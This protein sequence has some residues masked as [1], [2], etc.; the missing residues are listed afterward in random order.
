MIDSKKSIKT[1]DDLDI[2]EEEFYKVHNLNKSKFL[3]C[4]YE[5]RNNLSSNHNICDCINTFDYLNNEEYRNDVD[6][7]L[8]LLAPRQELTIRLMAGLKDNKKY[9]I[10]EICKILLVTKGRV[11][12]IIAKANH[13]LFNIAMYNEKYN[14]Q[15]IKTST[16]FP[17]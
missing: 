7:V 4:I 12:Q 8:H 5:I 13:H 3:K 15:K 16:D 9:T 6:N 10:E 17:K 14:K 1:K 2:V 11:N